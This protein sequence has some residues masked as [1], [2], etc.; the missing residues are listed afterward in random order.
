MRKYKEEIY[1]AII[2][3]STMIFLPP[4]FDVIFLE[5]WSLYIL[6]YNETVRDDVKRLS[7]G[8][9]SEKDRGRSY[10]TDDV[11]RSCVALG[12]PF[13]LEGSTLHSQTRIAPDAVSQQH[14]NQQHR[15]LISLF[16]RRLH[17]QHTRMKITVYIYKVGGWSLAGARAGYMLP[18]TDH[19]ARRG[20]LN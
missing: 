9:C 17:T 5:P 11:P 15:S 12:P 14:K 1:L 16:S 3:L 20:H 4:T 19:P 2:E 13:S 10:I 7:S 6:A 8:R 18:G